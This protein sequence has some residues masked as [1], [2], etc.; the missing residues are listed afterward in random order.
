MYPCQT[1]DF[2]LNHTTQ[3]PNV[4]S[5]PL[6]R[7]YLDNGPNMY[8]TGHGLRRP[9]LN[10]IMNWMYV[11]VCL[12]WIY[13]T[14]TPVYI[15][16]Y[17]HAI[18]VLFSWKI[19]TS[20]PWLTMYTGLSTSPAGPPVPWLVLLSG[21]RA[22]YDRQRYSLQFIWSL[23][24]TYRFIPHQETYQASISEFDGAAP[25]AGWVFH[26]M[27]LITDSKA[28]LVVKCSNSAYHR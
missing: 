8:R 6:Q 20:I 4:S 17:L 7:R 9:P 13:H 18:L 19:K 14:Y 5:W 12:L 28:C 1:N 23:L 11:S 25:V 26:I 16:I 10:N 21:F 3:C 2:C 15:Y 24:A 22:E 27:W